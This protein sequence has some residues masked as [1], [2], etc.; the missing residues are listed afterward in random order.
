MI[1]TKQG[2]NFCSFLD[3]LHQVLSEFAVVRPIRT[4]SDGRF[5]SP[6]V[7]AHHRSKRHRHSPED[8]PSDRNKFR[9][10][11]QTQ[12]D[13][14]TSHQT[15]PTD[16]SPPNQAEHSW[17]GGGYRAEKAE[18]FYNLTVFGQELHLQLRPN[19]RLVAPAATMEWWEE[20]GH[21]YSE[22]IGYAGCFY[23]GEVSNMEDTSVA[24][25]NCDGL[26]R[27]R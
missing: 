9:N 4:S 27:V 16:T 18:L 5:L 11:R 25:S 8:T 13:T 10:K 3:S 6:S 7:S 21:K 20:S 2:S 17:R 24:I 15:P 14:H 1:L 23:T 12:T 22:P 26:V 19:S